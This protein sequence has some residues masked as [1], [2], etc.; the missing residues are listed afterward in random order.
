MCH[1]V[2]VLNRTALQHITLVKCVGT[3]PKTVG[4][5]KLQFPGLHAHLTSISYILSVGLFEQVLCQ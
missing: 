5:V 3:C 2:D 4:D 1:S